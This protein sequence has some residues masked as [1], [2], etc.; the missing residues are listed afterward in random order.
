MSDFQELQQVTELS[1]AIYSDRRASRGEEK[2]ARA[3]IQAMRN[4]VKWAEE[5]LEKLIRWK[6]GEPIPGET[7]AC[8]PSGPRGCV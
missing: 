2:E 4:Y 1:L 3:A 8:D 7:H 5:E 6:R